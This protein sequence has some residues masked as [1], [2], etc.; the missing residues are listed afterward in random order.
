[1]K[2]ALLRKKHALLHAKVI[3]VNAI[4]QLKNVLSVGRIMILIAYLQW[5]IVK[6]L[7]LLV[8]ANQK[9]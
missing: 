3:S 8:N 5:T 2:M 6:L 9:H 1:M 7:N 4:T